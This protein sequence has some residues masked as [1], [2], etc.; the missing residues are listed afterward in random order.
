TSRLGVNDNLFEH[1]L[2][3]LL[4]MEVALDLSTRFNVELS[5]GE[6]AAHP[7]SRQVTGLLR[8]R[9]TGAGL[10]Q[11]TGLRERERLLLLLPP[12]LGSSLVFAG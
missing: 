7:T 4:A 12:V 9:Q 5:P 10:I 2:D 8:P 6:L 1:G 3:S 11:L